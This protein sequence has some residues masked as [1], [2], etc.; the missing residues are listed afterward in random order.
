MLYALCVS[1]LG[2]VERQPP[3]EIPAAAAQ[4][5]QVQPGAH[6]LG[7]PPRGHLHHRQLVPRRA[8]LGTEEEEQQNDVREDEQSHQVRV[9]VCV[10]CVCVYACLCVRVCGVCVWCVCHVCVS[11]VCGVCVCVWCG[12][13]CV[14][15]VHECVCEPGFQKKKP[16]RTAASKLCSFFWRGQSACNITVLQPVP[17]HLGGDP[18]LNQES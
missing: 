4:R 13:V 10:S 5:R 14:R 8:A 12:V 15:V 18:G 7:E 16:R 17:A 9:C 1:V 2:S 3:V 6:P 11:C